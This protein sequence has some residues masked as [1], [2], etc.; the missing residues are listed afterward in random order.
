MRRPPLNCGPTS[1]AESSA[2]LKHSHSVTAAEQA[3][4]RLQGQSKSNALGFE[5]P[6]PHADGK[7]EVRCDRCGNWFTR[8][9]GSGGTPQ[10]FCSAD[11]RKTSNREAQR[12]QRTGSYTGSISLP[13][14]EQTTQSETLPQ[15]P[16]LATMHPWE[17]GVL[18]IADCERTEF[19]VALN[20]GESAGTRVEMWPA[21]VRAFIDQHVGRWVEDNKEKHAVHAMTVAAPR[22]DGIQSCVV[23]LHHSP[24]YHAH[25]DSSECGAWDGGL[26]GPKGVS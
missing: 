8:R 24:K 16:V 23:I 9:H 17:T 21:E 18:N 1:N 11:C 7:L 19:V 15:P 26:A 6:A 5:Q 14:R 3:Y 4:D 20:E 13:P 22:Y 12:M 10:R 25:A 2:H